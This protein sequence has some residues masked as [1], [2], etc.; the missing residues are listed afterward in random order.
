L[1]N[2]LYIH[3]PFCE[4]KCPYCAFES[5]AN[6][7]VDYK[8]YVNA[9][10][11]TLPNDT[12]FQTVYFG[13]GTPS[14]IPAQLYVPLLKRFA[15]AVEITVE[16]NPSSATFEWL[17][18]IKE[19]GA[20]RISIG[21]QSV[22]ED[23]LKLLGRVHSVQMAKDAV[24]NAAKVGFTRISVDFIYD[25]A[26]DSP[27]SIE[28]ELDEILSLPIDHISL[29]ALTIEENTPFYKTPT[30]QKTNEDSA[31]LIAKKLADAKFEH[32]E[33]ASFGKTK[34]IHNLGYWQGSNYVGLGFGAVGFDGVK[35]YKSAAKNI[36]DYI[37]NPFA[38]EY[39]N[40]TEDERR[41]EQI[42]LGLRSIVGVN[43]NL[44]SNAGLENAQLLVNDGRLEF[45][46]G[47]FYNK[48]FW[49]SDEIAI[50]LDT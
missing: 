33:V 27:Q 49:I 48:N 32:Y 31:F 44:L 34:S 16:A 10:V 4:S 35:R 6:Q 50:F 7:K 25:T 22:R 36:A 28:K 40:I 21:V 9:I 24:I 29:Y 41:F 2:H 8:E 46:D 11:K 17:K 43:K 26:L 30:V 19:L 5:S 42:F 14:V 3:I 37:K 20:N 15:N 45:N 18:S 12:N 47:I 13:G 23:K 1:T 39:E 38:I